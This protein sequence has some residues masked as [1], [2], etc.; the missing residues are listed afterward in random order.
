MFCSHKDYSSF[1]GSKLTIFKLCNYG[2]MLAKVNRV[3]F[4]IVLAYFIVYEAYFVV[5]EFC[6][7]VRVVMFIL[8][9]MSYFLIYD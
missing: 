6:R 3:I 5:G 4:L 2:I 9:F 8:L 7:T 1:I